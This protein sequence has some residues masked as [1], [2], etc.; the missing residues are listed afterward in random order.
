MF[1]VTNAEAA[2][3]VNAVDLPSTDIY[4]FS[5]N[6]V[7]GTQRGRSPSR[8]RAGPLTDAEC[9]RAS[10]YGAQVRRV[11]RL[12]SPRGSKPVWTFVEVGHPASEDHWPSITPPQIRAAVWHSLIAGARGITYFNHSFGGP[13]RTQHALRDPCYASVRATVKATNR[14]IKALAPVL[15]AP[16]VTSRWTHSPATKAMVKW[17]RGHFYVFAGSAENVSS[18]ARSRSPASGTPP[19]PSS[20]RSAGFRSAEDGSATRSPTATRF[21]SIASTVARPAV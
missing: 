2:R 10:N 9:H 14:Q 21:T 13:C 20:G 11:R 19:P 3:Y 12:V 17:S 1:W 18:R 7:C 8:G 5:D 16:F 6:N 4:W 15:N